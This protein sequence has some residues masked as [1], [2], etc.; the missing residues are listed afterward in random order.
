[1]QD[2]VLHQKLAGM[3]GPD[4]PIAIGVIRNVSEP[5]YNDELVNQ[6]HDVQS[7]SS[8]KTFEDLLDSIDSWEI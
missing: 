5:T 1:M 6:I 4:F 2:F 7:K 8:V 3:T